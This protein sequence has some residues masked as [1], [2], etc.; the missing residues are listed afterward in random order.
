MSL[1]DEQT[2]ALLT[3]F[4]LAKGRPDAAS[5][6]VQALLDAERW[7]RGAADDVSGAFHALALTQGSLLK[8][9]YD[10]STHGH[11]PGWVVGAVIVD[12]RELTMVNQR[13]GFEVGDTVLR[14]T[15]KSLQAFSPQAKV[16][17]IHSDAFAM[18]L[19]PMA[20]RQVEPSTAEAVRER[21]TTEAPKLEPSLTYSIA[22]LELTLVSPSHW[23]VLGPLVWAECERALVMEQRSGPSGVQKRKVVLDGAVPLP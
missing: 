22:S 15:A 20:E 11:Q 17:R 13:H 19:G 12:I 21:L 8:E 23:Q 18:L 9:E 3:L 5:F 7:R 10:L 16:V 1:V 14:A 4:P 6:A 2:H